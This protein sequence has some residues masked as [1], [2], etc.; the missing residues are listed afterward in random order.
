VETVDEVLAKV[1]PAIS[2][3]GRERILLNPDCGF[4][5]FADTPVASCDIAEAKLRVVAQAAARLR[6]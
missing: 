1:Q 6:K 4:A 2:I 5:T 3:I